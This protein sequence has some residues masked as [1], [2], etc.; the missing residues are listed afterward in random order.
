VF[1]DRTPSPLVGAKPSVARRGR[2]LAAASLAAANL[3][4]VLTGCDRE[5]TVTERLV[6]KGVETIAPAVRSDQQRAD[7]A[8]GLA[9]SPRDSTDSAGDSANPTPPDSTPRP[10]PTAEAPVP[11]ELPDAW[12]VAPIAAPMR[13]ATFVAADPDAPNDSTAEAEITL[14]R[15]PGDV[16]GEL[17]NLNRWRRQVGLSPIAEPELE[18]AL[19]RFTT[20]GFTGYTVRLEGESHVLLAA[21]VHETAAD[22]TWFVKAVTDPAAADRI[23]PQLDDFARSFSTDRSDTAE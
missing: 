7:R 21:A 8:D 15:F 23:E 6:P 12:R 10:A 16:G 2:R 5:P 18:Q 1:I 20:P 9:S 19:T 3:L 14:T 11:Y 4:A 13:L 17:A 22:R